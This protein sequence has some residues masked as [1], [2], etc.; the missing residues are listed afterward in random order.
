M[1]GRTGNKGEKCTNQFGQTAPFGSEGPFF[2]IVSSPAELYR[3]RPPGK[4][5]DIESL[6]QEGSFH[7]GKVTYSYCL[8]G[9]DEDDVST[10][11]VEG[12]P[13]QRHLPGR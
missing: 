6:V 3:F 7:I 13:R 5:I 11:Q 12:L 2:P 9:S 1:D 8:F 10:F 4:M